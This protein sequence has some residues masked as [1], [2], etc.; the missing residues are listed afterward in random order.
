MQREHFE[1][2]QNREQYYK[3]QISDLERRIQSQDPGMRVLR[4]LRVMRGKDMS[5]RRKRAF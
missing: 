1:Q 5:K 3:G 2:L 4:L